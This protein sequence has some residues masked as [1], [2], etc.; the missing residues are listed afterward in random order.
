MDVYQLL[1][2]LIAL[3]A[4]GLSIFN[5]W[6][7]HANTTPRLKVNLSVSEHQKIPREPAV[8]R[9]D[10]KNVS[11][12]QVKLERAYVRVSRKTALRFPFPTGVRIEPNHLPRDLTAGGYYSVTIG[13][14]PAFKYLKAQGYAG[15]VR[16]TPYVVD[17]KGMNFFGSPI[18]LD[19][20][21]WKELP[22]VV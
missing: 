20:D 19:L 14:V 8:L 3:A 7:E 5:T 17:H 1:T 21:E 4:L 9:L 11:D 18:R 16:L 6:N 22:D 12:R 2:L 13:V 10:A 15:R